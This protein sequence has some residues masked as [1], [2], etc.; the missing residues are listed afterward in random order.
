MD[1]R[2]KA[3]LN[4]HLSATT[5]NALASQLEL[6]FEDNRLASQLYGDFDQNLALIEQR[7]AVTAA[8]RG[9]HLMLKGAASAVDQ[10]RRVLESLYALLE[11]GRS[12]DIA[13]VDTVIRMVQTEDSQLTLPTLEKKG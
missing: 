9:N 6:A 10:A 7:L 5:D 2:R 3:S 8:P 12:I 4:R 13:N 1:E 11:E